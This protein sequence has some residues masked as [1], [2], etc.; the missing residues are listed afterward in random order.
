MVIA[1]QAKRFDRLLGGI[2]APENDGPRLAV[3]DPDRDVIDA[4]EDAHSA[5][6]FA[7]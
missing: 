5:W 1:H 7:R 4:G 6:I 2:V 3:G